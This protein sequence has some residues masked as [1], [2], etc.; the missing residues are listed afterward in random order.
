LEGAV[1]PW[2]DGRM[3]MKDLEVDCM[4]IIKYILIKEI[5]WTGME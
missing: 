4:I 1:A 2:M 5:D 3:D